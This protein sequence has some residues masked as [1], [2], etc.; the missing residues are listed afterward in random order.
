MESLFLPGILL[1]LATCF[2]F[3]YRKRSG[4]LKSKYGLNPLSIE[5]DLVFGEKATIILFSSAFCSQCRIAKSV[6]TNKVKFFP[7]ISYVEIDAES[8]LKLVRELNI[9]STP[10][11]IILNQ[12]RFEFARAVGVPKNFQL[13]KLLKS[14]SS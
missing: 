2:G 7:E 8:N 1:F 6:I 14:I 5:L 4:L 10:T 12:E 11:T 3:Y 13:E 9:L